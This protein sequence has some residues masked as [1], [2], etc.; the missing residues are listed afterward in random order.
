MTVLET[1]WEG[2]QYIFLTVQVAVE[3]FYADGSTKC[4]FTRYF[5]HRDE[6]VVLPGPLSHSSRQGE[7]RWSG[8]L[9]SAVETLKI[10]CRI[11]DTCVRNNPLKHIIIMEQMVCYILERVIHLS[12]NLVLIKDVLIRGFGQFDGHQLV[13][14]I[15]KK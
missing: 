2:G 7:A 1:P 8:H 4:L 5:L 13:L 6:H 12:S 10:P 11:T 15:S 14:F 3:T 9:K